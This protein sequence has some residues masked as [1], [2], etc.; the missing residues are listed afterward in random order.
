MRDIISD[1]YAVHA[2]LQAN[3]DVYKKRVLNTYGTMIR[4]MQDG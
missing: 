3:D 2:D 1:I 4:E